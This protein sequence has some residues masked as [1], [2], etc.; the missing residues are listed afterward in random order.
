MDARFCFE[1]QNEDAKSVFRVLKLLLQKFLIYLEFLN[2]YMDAGLRFQFFQLLPKI[3]LVIWNPDGR[4][5]AQ[6]FI[7][8]IEL[9]CSLIF[10]IFVCVESPRNDWSKNCVFERL[11]YF[12]EKTENAK[13]HF[14][15][16]HFLFEDTCSFSDNEKLMSCFPNYSVFA[17][18][19]VSAVTSDHF[20]SSIQACG[21][22]P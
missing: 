19:L 22:S 3:R 2:L 16:Q 18:H 15:T 8:E 1:T 14:L 6:D 11:Q 17:F 13:F 10:I 20:F 21:A 5:W 7:L 12:L 9:F 4:L